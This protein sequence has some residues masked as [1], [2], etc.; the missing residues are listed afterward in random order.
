MSPRLPPVSDRLHPPFR[1][2][3]LVRRW[4]PDGGRDDALLRGTDLSPAD[5]DDPA[6]KVSTAQY[7]QAC[8]NA[9]A[10]DVAATR[11]DVGG[12]PR[13]SDHGL[14][15]LLLRSCAS[16]R[17]VFRLAV[18]YQWLASPLVAIDAVADGE[19]LAWTIGDDAFADVPEAF[20]A[21]V[22]E[23]RFAELAAHLAD[24]LGADV[25]PVVARFAR[26]AP[27][28]RAAL[29][30]VLRCPCEF[31]A[32][33]DALHYA[34]AVASRRLPL[35]NPLAAATLER[36]CDG[37]VAEMEAAIGIAGRV[38]RTLDALRDPG[39]PM[40]VVAAALKTTDRTLRRRL[41]DEGTSF[42]AISHRARLA[43]ATRH[44]A[45]STASIDEVATIAGFSDPANFRRAFIR[46][47][48]MSPA[49]FR[50]S[51]PTMAV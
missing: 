26:R 48:S 28:H 43:A 27:T 16:G 3:H 21:F 50:R 6:T 1:L 8:A 29:A 10:G 18:R 51:R 32:D 5:L 41:S 19:G 7:L 13:L 30:A 33:T 49:Q 14:Y 25:R 15:G 9:V 37:L 45:T 46:W 38:L 47:T 44:L 39:A 4:S 31:D 34:D 12:P 40:K 2:A 35:A 22:V 42:S 23:H 20:R 11:F 36:T 17:D 24:A